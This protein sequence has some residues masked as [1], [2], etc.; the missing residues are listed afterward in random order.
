[1][2]VR[3]SKLVHAGL[4]VP[5]FVDRPPW[6][7]G[8]LQTLRNQI[9]PGPALLAGQSRHLQFPTSDGSGDQLTGTIETPSVKPSGPLIF[10]VHGLAGCE[11]SAY[12]RESARFHLLQGRRVLRLNLRGAGSSRATCRGYYC[13]G[14]ASDLQDVMDGLDR[15]FVRDGIFAIGYS[16]G[17]NI[18]LNLLPRLRDEY[19]VVGA[20]TVSAP[21]HPL[22]A[23]KRLMAW[24]NSIYHHTL[25]R[26]MKI[27]SLAPET[28]L[29]PQERDA[30]AKTRSVYEFDNNFTA[31]RNG[32]R[33]AEDYYERTAGMNFV[34]CSSVPLLMVHA[35]NDPWIP[36]APY[37]ELQNDSPSNVEIVIARSGGHVGFHAKDSMW[38]WHDRLIHRF[39]NWVSS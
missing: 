37:R 12:I 17:G 14:C 22:Q 5:A 21:I 9:V 11:D 16:L 30:I 15:D 25:L 36:I 34:R 38:T 7:G 39:L 26:R 2:P 19:A 23:A 33:D 4:D 20:V 24:R 31:P 18:L 32:F 3:M 1:M 28:G 6:W 13:A 35:E 27:E 8:D 29:S 10:L